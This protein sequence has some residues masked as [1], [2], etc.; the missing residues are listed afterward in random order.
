GLDRQRS[1]VVSLAQAPTMGHA[2]V[3]LAP[4]L[5]E[6]ELAIQICAAELFGAMA[7]AR[8]H[9]VDVLDERHLGRVHQRLAERPRIRLRRPA[10]RGAA[11]RR[12]GRGY[13]PLTW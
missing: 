2:Q 4:P 3:A 10:L 13:G 6:A 7:M 12:S 1:D 9:Q 11:D 5:A 8:G